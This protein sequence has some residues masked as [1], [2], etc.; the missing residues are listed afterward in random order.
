VTPSFQGGAI[1]TQ[2]DSP[3]AFDN[4]LLRL[5]AYSHASYEVILTS[6]IGTLSRSLS[7]SSPRYSIKS[8]GRFILLKADSA[9]SV[10]LVLGCFTYYPP[11]DY[12]GSVK[13]DISVT[14]TDSDNINRSGETASFL[15]FVEPVD[16]A[17][18]EIV[19]SSPPYLNGKDV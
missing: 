4:K 3:W 10:N 8:Y 12:Y 11:P 9:D 6:E 18:E 19:R 14:A 16:G 17:P 2:G 15:I 1:R 13:I 5:N 7:A